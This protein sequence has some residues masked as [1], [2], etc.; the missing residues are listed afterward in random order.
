MSWD[1]ERVEGLLAAHALGGL[2]E[3]DEAEAERAIAEH[4]PDCPPC[5]R[6]MLDFREVAGDLALAAPAARP[7]TARPPTATTRP[8]VPVPPGPEPSAPRAPMR[9]AALAGAAALFLGLAGWTFTLADRLGEAETRQDWFVDAVSTFGDPE[10][11]VIPLRGTG[12]GRIHLLF[13]EG[14]QPMYLVASG[15]EAPA[16]GVF[17][18]WLVRGGGGSHGGGTFLPHDGVAMVRV[19]P[20]P[21]DLEVVMVTHEPEAGVPTPTASPIAVATVAP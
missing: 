17:K 13:H 11:N 14:G 15:M 6:A 9:W 18:V 10:G 12:P 20:V 1:H 5:H 8:L 19:E 16:D 4:C 3:E 2:E 7:P 21:D